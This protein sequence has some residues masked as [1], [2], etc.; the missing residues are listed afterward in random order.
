MASIQRK[1]K[2][3]KDKNGNVTWVVRFRPIGQKEKSRSFRSQKEA[4]QFKADIER[5][6]VRNEYVDASKILVRDLVETHR[7][8]AINASS[9]AGR[10]TLLANLGDLANMPITA[11]KPSDIEAW[12]NVLL[13]NR[14]WAKDGKPLAES[15]VQTNLALLHGIFTK[16]VNDDQLAR[17]PMRGVVIRRVNTSVRREDIPTAQQIYALIEGAKTTAVGRA[18]DPLLSL[19]IQVASETGTR[20]GELCGLRVR[21]IDFLRKEI[22]I[23]EQIKERTGVHGDLKSGSKPRTVPVS[24]ETLKDIEAYL[25]ANPRQPEEC[26]FLTSERKPI[27]SSRMGNRFSRLAKRYGY[28]FTLHSLRHFYASQLIASGCPINIVQKALGHATP[29]MTLNTYVHLL[30]DHNERL[31]D[32]VRSVRDICGIEDKKRP[33]ANGERAARG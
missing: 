16:A 21:N 15:T 6:L 29:A 10:T 3:G 23:V 31:R 30:D 17:H 5:K 13:T 12:R 18:Q 33:P 14:P 26:L 9:K 27:R 2:T 4:K 24:D 8:S 32:S 7:D 25:A 19:F 11:V 22:H 28:T 1:P 20:A